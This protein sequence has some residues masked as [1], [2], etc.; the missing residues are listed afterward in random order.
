VTRAE[1]LD[2]L[3][4]YE[5]AI[6]STHEELRPFGWDSDSV[7]V[8]LLPEHIVNVLDRFLRHELN[9]SQVEIWANAIETRDDIGY[10]PMS[11][12]GEALHELANPEITDSLT[13]ERA[14]AW[15]SLLNPEDDG[16][17]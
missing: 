8:L 11:V 10:D 1:L 14:L 4:K 3:I 6:E 5:R 2:E 13:I 17:A 7:L 12:C 16:S 9:A 15:L